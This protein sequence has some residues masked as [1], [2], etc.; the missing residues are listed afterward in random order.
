[1]R[2]FGKHLN[3]DSWH[4]APE[5]QALNNREGESAPYGVNFSFSMELTKELDA[6]N[7]LCERMKIFGENYRRMVKPNFTGKDLHIDISFPVICGKEPILVDC[8]I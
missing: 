4:I 3:L 1:M 6:Y 7:Y 5:N 2:R 8:N